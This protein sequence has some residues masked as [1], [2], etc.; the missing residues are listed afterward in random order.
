MI[1]E[2]IDIIEPRISDINYGGHVGHVELIYLLHEIR[3]RFLD[4]YSLQ[5]TDING[6]V[7]VMHNLNLTYKNQVFWNNKLEVNMKTKIDGVKII[8]AYHVINT[9]REKEAA[10]ATMTM[11]LLD[12]K[13]GKPIKPDIFVKI[14]KKNNHE[15]ICQ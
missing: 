2:Y 8:F 14:L 7:L 3:V 10:M 13:R 12:K 6:H 11:V 9:T 5:E 4:K 15:K 1:I